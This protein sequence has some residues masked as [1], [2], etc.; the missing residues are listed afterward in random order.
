MAEIEF[1]PQI[2][3]EEWKEY[4]QKRA[5]MIVDNPGYEPENDYM[6]DSLKAGELPENVMETLKKSLS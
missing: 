6:K 2:T 4:E 3:P 1:V 5:Q